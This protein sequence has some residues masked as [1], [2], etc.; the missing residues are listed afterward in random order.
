MNGDPEQEYFSDS[1]MEGIITALSH[2]R[3]FFVIA[4]STTFTFKDQAVDVQTVAREMGPLL[5]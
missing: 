5:T 4:R 3:Q 1:I 2:I